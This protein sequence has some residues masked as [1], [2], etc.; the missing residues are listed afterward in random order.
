[1]LGL[2]QDETSNNL[3]IIRSLFPQDHFS[4]SCW[5]WSCVFSSLR[6]NIMEFSLEKSASCGRHSNRRM[7]MARLWQRNAVPAAAGVDSRSFQG[8]ELLAEDDGPL[9]C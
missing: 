4:D 5:I 1:M 8:W 7:I 6:E 2:K 3:K 9:T